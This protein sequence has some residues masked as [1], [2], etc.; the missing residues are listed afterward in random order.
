MYVMHAR[1]C[2]MSRNNLASKSSGLHI[3]THWDIRSWRRRSRAAG[4]ERRPPRGW[5]GA[6]ASMLPVWQFA[7][8]GHS[9]LCIHCAGDG[10][11]QMINWS[12][13]LITTAHLNQICV[14]GVW[15]RAWHQRPRREQ[16]KVASK[17]IFPLCRQTI[18]QTV[19]SHSS[20]EDGAG[21][22]VGG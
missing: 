16:Q 13:M 9:M 14:K 20:S 18:L 10:M 11:G 2:G 19:R 21:H 3:R 8:I 7:L 15:P 5:V 22:V 17:A 6:P 12:D 1:P 4:T